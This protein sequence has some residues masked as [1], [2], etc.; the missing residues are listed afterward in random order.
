MLITSFLLISGSAEAGGRDS[1]L[2]AKDSSYRKEG[3]AFSLGVRNTVNI[4]T[5]TPNS[6]GLGVGGSARLQILKRLNT[7]WFGDYVMN[8]IYNKASR[9]DG[10]IGWNVM[11]YILDPKGFSR[12]FTPFIAAGHCFD[13]TGIRLN[14]EN[15]PMH[16][17][18]T[19]AVQMSIGCHYNITPQFDI[20]VSTLYD[21]HLGKEI[22]AE[23]EKDG[24][25]TIVEH[26]NAGWEGHIML[27]FSAHYKFMRLWK[28][29]K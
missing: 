25:L 4:F 1:P 16:E 11:F 20:S 18:W 27:I 22:D 2:F 8:N 14:G 29:K 6:F 21:L 26:A 3:G 17:R 28:S 12:K 23:V 19:S 15:Q 5:N 13:Y 9:T 7:E 10:H 24:T